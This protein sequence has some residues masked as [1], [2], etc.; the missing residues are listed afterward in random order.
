M[1]H[2]LLVSGAV[3]LF[4]AVGGGL[5]TDVGPWYHGLRKP[6]LNP[7]D[8]L[9]GPAWTLILAAWAV[10]AAYAWKHAGGPADQR[11][12]IILFAVSAV[13]HFAWSPLFFKAKRPDWALGEVMFLWA[14]VLALVIGL[15]P[16]SRRASALIV[17]YLFWV[18]FATWLNREI[19]RLNRPFAPR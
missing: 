6:T 11:A 15:W 7:P 16:I 4:L 14:S 5:L 19:V 8:W 2:P 13:C 3:A 1:L 10:S 12:I 18:S 9:F 17:P